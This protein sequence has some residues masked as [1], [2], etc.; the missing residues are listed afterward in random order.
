MKFLRHW[1]MI[2]GLLAIFGT[3]MG[4]GAVGTI[5]L[6]HRVFTKPVVS[7]SWAEA[8][9]RDLET[10][11]KLTPEQKERIKPIAE[12]TADR[13]RA[14]GAEAFEK[15]VATAQETHEEIRNELT[16]EQQAE[17]NRLR[18]QV[19]SALRELAQR[20]ISVKG[21][22]GRS[23]APDTPGEADKAPRAAHP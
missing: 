14:I 1:K 9:L 22:G 6:L 21:Q 5:V 16:P 7:R 3:G 11:L 17:F 23:G 19:I 15:I 18:P 2:L 13:F 4:T 10:R 20:E 8:R 12:R